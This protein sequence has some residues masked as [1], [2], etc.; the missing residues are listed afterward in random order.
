MKN[1]GNAFVPTDYRRTFWNEKEA[2]AF[3]ERLESIADAENVSISM[4]QDPENSRRRMY[5]VKWD[6]ANK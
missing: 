6:E 3:V 5:I 4:T 2:A 1:T